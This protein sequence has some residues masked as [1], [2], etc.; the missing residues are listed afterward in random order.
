MPTPTEQKPP[1]PK[2]SPT[3]RPSAGR[4]CPRKAVEHCH[5]N[6]DEIQ[7]RL[8]SIATRAVSQSNISATWLKGFPVTKPSL[9]EQEEI[10][11]HA[12]ALDRKLAAHRF[13]RTQLQ[14]LFRTLLHEL[15]TA[16]T[17]V[18]NLTVQ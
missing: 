1:K 15:M 2:S 11:V 9:E 6:T 7:A 5:F 18:H 8:K 13:K 4:L 17:R 10:V 14:D 12:K 3:P 16:K